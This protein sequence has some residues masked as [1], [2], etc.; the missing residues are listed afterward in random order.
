[1]PK[2]T[3][4][5][6]N[7]DT[8]VVDLNTNVMDLE[9]KSQEEF[10]LYFKQFQKIYIETTDEMY[11]LDK[12]RNQAIDKMKE[13]QIRYKEVIKESNLETKK[14]SESKKESNVKE[15]EVDEIN[16]VDEIDEVEIKKVKDK[17]KS[18]P[19][20]KTTKKKD[21]AVEKPKPKSKRKTK[22]KDDEVD[23]VDDESK[24]PKTKSKPKKT[25]KKDDD[26]E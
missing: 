9:L 23:E 19:T 16:E 8:K 1:M 26:D 17:P 10:N 7:T 24:K 14:E 2:N 5:Q 13:I 22:K 18:K 12:K 20:R 25:K 15:D 6:N 21:D 11:T 3:K 4:K